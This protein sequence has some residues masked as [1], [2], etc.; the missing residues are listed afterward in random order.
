MKKYLLTLFSVICS[1]TLFGQEFSIGLLTYKVINSTNNYVEVKKK[2][3]DFNN[4]NVQSLTIPATVNNGATT[5]TV[6]KIANEGFMQSNS[7]KTLILPSTITEIGNSAFQ[8][9]GALELVD[10]PNTVSTIGSAAFQECHKLHSIQLPSSLTTISDDLFHSCH[11]LNEIIIPEGI[12]SI[13][14]RAFQN[15][16]DVKIIFLGCGD[17]NHKITINS[18]AFTNCYNDDIEILCL[19]CVLVFE[20]QSGQP[21]NFGN[22]T[23]FQVPCGKSAGYT[24]IYNNVTVTEENC[25]S[26]SRRSG[27]F[28]LPETWEGYE[29]WSDRVAYE[30]AGSTYEAKE[31]WLKNG[32]DNP[33]NDRYPTFV[34]RNPDHPFYIKQ[35]DTVEL[36]HSRHIYPFNSI[37]K[38]VLKVNTQEGGQLIERDSLFFDEHYTLEVEYQISKVGGNVFITRNH[39]EATDIT[40]LI[41][42]QT[43]CGDYRYENGFYRDTETRYLLNITQTNDTY[44]VSEVDKDYYRVEN[45]TIYYYRDLADVKSSDINS[46]TGTPNTNGFYK[47]TESGFTYIKHNITFNG[48]T[49]TV[50]INTG[51]DVT[52]H[53]TDYAYGHVR[54]HENLGGEIEIVV[55]ATQGRWNF[56]G[57]PFN[58]YDLWSVKI[59]P[60]GSDVTIV[61]FDYAN[62]QWSDIFSTVDDEINPGEGFLAWPFYDGG[63][64]FS[65]KRDYGTTSQVI[66]TKI[67]EEDFALN[68]DTVIVEKT[69]T[70]TDQDGR[71]MA[72]ANPYPAKLC[73]NSFVKDNTPPLQDN[74]PTLQGQGVY[75]LTNEVVGNKQK[76][77]FKPQTDVEANKYDLGVGQG[78]FV[79]VVANPNPTTITFTK[80]QLHEYDESTCG[81]EDHSH[82]KSATIKEFVKIVMIE[83][84]VETELLFA[85]NP[86]SEQEYDI[87]DANKLFSMSEISEPYFVTDGIA[88]VKEEVKDLPY[89]ATMNVRSFEEKQVSFKA[90]EIPEGY[91]VSIIDG[92]EV[93]SLNN[94]EIYTT[95][96]VAGENSDRFKILFGSSVG[97]EDVE[98]PEIKIVNSNR[99]VNISTSLT[100]LQI[101]VYNALGQKVYETKDYNFI[102]ND[103]SAGAY[104]VKAFNK[105]NNQTTKIIIK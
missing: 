98:N 73:V 67:M 19:E 27:P 38:G 88:L 86:D 71:W 53:G 62:K 35:G 91:L 45:N 102:L 95:N 81:H 65:T 24:G 103:L 80:S 6:T 25:V 44:S 70:G 59:G 49:T 16:H 76:F 52:L 78:F 55:P 34:P 39:H 63:I 11:N 93:I 30:A 5:Y 99:N 17:A 37:N 87:Y 64:I 48:Q 29:S 33:N 42:N 13:S 85:Q 15:T 92:E 77:E 57:A 1:I 46:L 4:S 104:M 21:I 10:M 40:D 18:T 9:C 97:L 96:I 22:N 83:D 32:D 8:G 47:V 41:N 51:G 61:E 66:G 56:V 84:G 72:L 105:T 12:V 79:N 89:Y 31:A 2:Q 94:G 68:N 60:Y 54:M 74:T 101:E 75:V 82:A 20:D 26:I 100:N 28:C 58:G 90:V 7:L 14:A 3:N 36:N 50:T 69:I 23:M 43:T